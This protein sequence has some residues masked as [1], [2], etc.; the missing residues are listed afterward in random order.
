MKAPSLLTVLVSLLFLAG[1]ASAHEIKEGQFSCYMSS[2]SSVG[3]DCERGVAAAKVCTEKLK[4]KL[5]AQ[6]ERPKLEAGLP[7]PVCEYIPHTK[8]IPA[9]VCGFNDFGSPNPG[10]FRC[11]NSDAGGSCHEQCILVEC[12]TDLGRKSQEP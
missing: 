10:R 11:G 12:E 9:I 6:A 7:G 3:D 2:C 8:T 4:A 1:V 5:K